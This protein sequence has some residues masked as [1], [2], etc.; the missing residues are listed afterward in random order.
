MLKL[1][2]FCSDWPKFKETLRDLLISMKQ[3][4]SS[5]DE[6]YQDEKNVSNCYHHNVL[7]TLL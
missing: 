3:H 2:N 4:S 5:N 7:L 1:F 6:F